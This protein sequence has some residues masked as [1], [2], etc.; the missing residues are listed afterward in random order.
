MNAKNKK[1]FLNPNKG[2]FTSGEIATLL[3]DKRLDSEKIQKMILAPDTNKEKFTRLKF[4]LIGK[5]VI[6]NKIIEAIKVKNFVTITELSNILEQEVR[7]T[8][9]KNKAPF[10]QFLK[11]FLEDEKIT[12]NGLEFYKAK[13][14]NKKTEYNVITLPKNKLKELK[15]IKDIEKRE[16]ERIAELEKVRDHISKEEVIVH[17]DYTPKLA[18]Y[19]KQELVDLY[20]INREIFNNPQRRGLYPQAEIAKMERQQLEILELLY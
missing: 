6:I 17:I 20:Y 7:L 3:N 1:E 12:K 8:M 18:R 16:Q 5:K 11:D 14:I 2:G 15:K 10:S 19:S 4:F 9:K 13:K